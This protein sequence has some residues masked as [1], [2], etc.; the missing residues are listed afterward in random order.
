MCP[1]EL[2]S[3]ELKKTHMAA[4]TVGGRSNQHRMMSCFATH[5]CTHTNQVYY[6]SCCS[7][8]I[9]TSLYREHSLASGME[10]GSPTPPIQKGKP[11]SRIRSGKSHPQIRMQ[12]PP[13]KASYEFH[14]WFAH[15]QCNCWVP[16][17]IMTSGFQLSYDTFAIHLSACNSNAMCGCGLW[18]LMF[19]PGPLLCM[20]H[21]GL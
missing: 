20:Q 21:Y 4:G 10:K 12:S 13:P 15:G 6:H 18:Q 17:L 16:I 14:F 5:A 9:C 7:P 2:K 3:Q 8:P 1:Q 19:D 11:I